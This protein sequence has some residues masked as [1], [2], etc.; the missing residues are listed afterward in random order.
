MLHSKRRKRVDDCA[1]N[2]RRGADRSSLA[3]SLHA[4]WINRRWR[5]G[6]I[7][8]K[9][10]NMRRAWHR[11]VHQSA[12]NQ[13][14]IFVV[15]NFFKQ[16]LSDRLHDAAVHL[17]IYEQWIDHPAAIVHGDVTK[18]LNVTRF[19]IDFHNRDVRSEGEREVFG[20]EEVG[21]GKPGLGVWREILRDVRC[22]RN[23]LNA[24]TR[25]A[26]R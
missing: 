3:D 24:H 14:S 10:R 17:S 5:L 18:K 21:G 8:F 13:L 6:A 1:N 15:N 23:F 20:F 16:R 25:A 22:K 2:R 4:K 19:A 9:V 26:D 7:E 12:R 11:V